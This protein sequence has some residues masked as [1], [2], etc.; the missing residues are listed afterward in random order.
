MS[1]QLE[2]YTPN[3][4][5]FDAYYYGWGKLISQEAINRDGR[6][7][8]CSTVDYGDDEYRAGYQAGRFWSGLYQA[9][10]KKMEDVGG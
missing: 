10:V 4:E 7:V 9:E 1:Y 6:T 3:K 2:V 8:F 5:I